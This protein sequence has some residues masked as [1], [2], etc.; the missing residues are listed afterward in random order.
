MS[1]F[2]RPINGE[3]ARITTEYSPSGK[4]F[5][6]RRD[7]SSNLY[8]FFDGVS[9]EQ[10][11]IIDT[12][13]GLFDGLFPKTST[14]LLEYHELDL[15]IPDDI[16]SGQGSIE[17]RQRDVIVKKYMMRG[18]RLQDFYDIANIYGVTVTI[19]TGLQVAVFPLL[20][21]IVFSADA[22]AERNTLYIT[23]STDADFIFPLPFPI[24]FASES[25]VDKVKKIYNHIKPAT[26]RIVYL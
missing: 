26:T 7:T 4:I 16:F 8:K 25:N 2:N 21:P 23:I 24:Q 10:G 1:L 20:F 9:K 15:G 6:K 3:L 5:A 13:N 19:K 14:D 11:R 22:D 18:N 17:D 12:L